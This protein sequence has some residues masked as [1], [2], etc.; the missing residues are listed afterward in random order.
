[1]IRVRMTTT[2]EVRRQAVRG[3]ENPLTIT[4]PETTLPAVRI[5]EPSQKVI[6]GAVLHHHHHDMIDS[7][8]V[9]I[10]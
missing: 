4:V 3:V 8:R 5:F 1:M 2:L 6:K 9:R 7:R 10:G